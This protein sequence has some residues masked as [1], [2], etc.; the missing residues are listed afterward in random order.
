ML[1]H[2]SVDSAAS[3][4]ATIQ[5][6]WSCWSQLTLQPLALAMPAFRA[7]GC[8]IA[9]GTVAVLRQQSISKGL[10]ALLFTHCRTLL[11][12]T[13]VKPVSL[14]CLHRSFRADAPIPAL[15]QIS[16][17]AAPPMCM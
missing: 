14:C 4:Q 12:A 1:G 9:K 17:D 6:L 2:E 8:Q 11:Q 3:T 16:I 15:W 10:C 5:A 13:G 7:S